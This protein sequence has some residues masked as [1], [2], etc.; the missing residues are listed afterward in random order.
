MNCLKDRGVLFVTA[1]TLGLASCGGGGGGGGNSGGVSA[2]PIQNASPG[3]IWQGRNRLGELILGLVAEDGRFQFIV[4]D[5]VPYTQYWGTLTTSGNTISGSN[6]QVAYGTTYLG[7]ATLTGGS[8]TARQTMAG[9]LNY[10]PVAGCSPTVCP[11]AQSELTTL[12]FNPV[13][14]QGGALSRIVGNWRDAFTGQTVN[15]NASG[16]FFSQDAGTGCI[17]N[18]QV[19]T[20]NTTYNAYS[21]TYTF[22]GCRFPYNIQNGTT[23]TGLAFVDT[24]VS[25]NNAYFAGQYRVGNTAYAV[26]AAGPKI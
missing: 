25:P 22:S 9:T 15:I 26:Y 7:T 12:T 24:S 1:L 20:I 18:G 6:F 2:P 16:V 11:P 5:G 23:A 14:N 13:Y 21:V 8:I 4:E 17:T 3:G 10:T 19:S